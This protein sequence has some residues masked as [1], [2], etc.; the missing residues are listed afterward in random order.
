LEISELRDAGETVVALYRQ[1]AK[2]V[3][4]GTEVAQQGGAVI[5]G[6][7]KGRVSEVSFFLTWKQ[8]LE[9]VG[10]DAL[11]SAVFSRDRE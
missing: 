10:K 11:P 9:A 8:A 3:R 1:I 2:D 7:R 6:F 5:S 4:S